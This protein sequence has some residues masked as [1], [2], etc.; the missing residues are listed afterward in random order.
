MSRSEPKISVHSLKA[1]LVVVVNT[2]WPWQGVAKVPVTAVDLLN[3]RVLPFFEQQGVPV[4]R[5]LTD[6]GTEFC[7]AADK[8]P[9]E[10]FLQLNEIEH[11]KTKAKSPH[12]NAICERAH[13]TFLDEFYRVAFLKKVYWAL[14][15]LRVDLDE[16]LVYYNNERTHQGKRCQGRTPMAT[17][18]EGKRFFA[19]KNLSSPLTA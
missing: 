14:K 2:P 6:R 3:D 11:T 15:A 4:L 12:T 1:K 17:F 5:V 9:Y 10:L 7:G 18:L 8:H 13:Q 16:Y 19:E